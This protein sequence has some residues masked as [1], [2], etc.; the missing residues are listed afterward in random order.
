MALIVTTLVF[1]LVVV[2]ISAV[3]VAFP[4]IEE[5]FGVST[6]KLAWMLSGYNITVAALLMASGRLAD[7]LGRK[8]LFIPG[9]AVFM[10]G[11]ICCGLA[12]DADQ[13]IAARVL[14]AI[15]G[16]IISPTAIAVV[17]P[18]FPAAKRSLAIGIAGATAGL[19]A[20]AGPA[21]GSILIETWSWR[22]IFLINVPICLTVLVLAPRLLIE[23]KNPNATGKIDVIGAM[24]GTVAITS[25]MFAI[26]GTESRGITDP[27]VVALAIG[28]IALLPIVVQRSRT[29]PEPL[30]ELS[31]FKQRSFSS[32]NAGVALYSMAFPSGFLM[33]SLLLQH[34]WDQTITTTG[35]ALLPAPLL[36]AVLSPLAGRYADRIGHRW[37]LAGGTSMI[38]IGYLL[39][40]LV[41]GDEPHVFDHFVPISLLT[42]AGVGISIATWNSAAL[43]DVA[44]E[45]FGTANA[46]VRTTQQV[47]YALGIS[48]VITLLAASDEKLPGF[49][50]AWLWVGGSYMASALLIALT[51]PAGNSTERAAK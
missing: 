8:K 51:F 34:H 40:F 42:G 23:S 44:P 22:G 3:N 4:S 5:D 6:S 1:F 7:S 28:G 41:L 11:S 14:Q 24:L 50:H 10:L 43:S 12:Q 15:G 46:T 26:V 39:Y 33:N 16:S 37:I 47:F 31:L 35:K 19:G 38:G 29:H 18:A 25:I 32:T 21:I 48:V 49:R 20:V 45:N 27:R 36:S 30:I 17:L 2:D 9:V 13:L